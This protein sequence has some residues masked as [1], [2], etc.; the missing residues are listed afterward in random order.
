MHT[1]KKAS[2]ILAVTLAALAGCSQHKEQPKTD[3]PVQ[4]EAAAPA[5]NA[6]A[7][8]ASEKA[9]APAVSAKAP[10]KETLAHVKDLSAPKLQYFPKPVYPASMQARCIEGEARVTMRIS[11]EGKPEDIKIA[12]STDPA[13]SESLMNVL[14]GWRFVP[15]EKDGVAVARTVS[16]AIPF[17]INNRPVDLPPEISNG[18]PELLGVVRPPHPGKGAAKA[19]VRFTITS[20]TI[21]SGV[22]ILSTEGTVDKGSLLDSL[23]QW[24]FL[25]SRYSKH[26][27]PQ[28]KVT[29][30]ITFTGAGNVLIQYPYP[31]PPLPSPGSAQT[32]QK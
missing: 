5:T 24:V 6:K 3:A 14:P 20:D 12:D 4:Q 28:T 17:I 31:I 1:A 16:I 13:F 32:P 11:P 27:S 8:P 9:A 23:G 10:E 18:E 7:T 15:A 19:I 29:A 26:N 21:V 22:D 2:W 30:E 25:P